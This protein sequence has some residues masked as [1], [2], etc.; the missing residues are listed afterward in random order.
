MTIYQ[1]SLFVLYRI[2]VKPDISVTEDRMELD[3][4]IE[5]SYE[6]PLPGTSR[7]VSH[8]YQGVYQVIN[9]SDLDT[10]P[11]EGDNNNVSSDNSNYSSESTSDGEP[12]RFITITADITSD[13]VRQSADNIDAIT[14]DIEPE[15]P[16]P[17]KSFRILPQTFNQTI[18]TPE[19]FDEDAACFPG[20]A[21]LDQ[22]SNSDSDISYDD[23]IVPPVNVNYPLDKSDVSVRP[24]IK[25]L[26][27]TSIK[28]LSDSDDSSP[29]TSYDDTL[30]PTTIT[31][32]NQ[33]TGN[34]VPANVTQT[35]PATA[36]V[37]DIP[38]IYLTMPKPVLPNNPYVNSNI[39]PP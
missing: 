34:D 12:P 28:Q 13:N 19:I 16:K 6:Q 15:P 25:K 1:L 29:D 27:T 5:E 21:K 3:D 36:S 7:G 18:E 26:D 39:K 4:I 30:L 32:N 8:S 24:K 37:L 31:T 35:N 11:S 2:Q 17:H 38:D 9:D 23:T 10:D 14:L 22:T 33:I 20:Q